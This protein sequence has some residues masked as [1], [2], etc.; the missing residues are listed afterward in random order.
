MR[1]QVKW[2][3]RLFL[4]WQIL[5]IISWAQ[6]EMP[7]IFSN[8]M[9]LQRHI[10]IPI[11]GT[12]A[13]NSAVVV[14]L[15]GFETKTQSGIDGKWKVY[16]PARSAGGPFKLRIING[17]QTLVYSDILIGEVWLCSGQSNMAFELDKSTNSEPD[18]SNAEN[19]NIRLFQMSRRYN[20]GPSVFSKEE[21]E[22]IE[23]GHFFNINPWVPSTPQSVAKFS[24]VAYYFGKKLSDSLQI[25]I[26]L[27]HNAIGGSTIE[28]W[29]NRENMLAHPQLSQLAT[30]EWY[31]HPNIHPWVG[32][33]VKKNL[34]IWLDNSIADKN[35]SHPFAPGYLY[36]H[37]IKPLLPYAIRGVIW[38]QGESNATHPSSYATLFEL[39]VNNWR[40]SWGQDNLPIYFVQLPRIANRSRWPEFREQQS[41]CL[42]IPNT[43]MVIA[44]DEGHRTNVHPKNKRPVGNRLALLALAQT[45]KYPILA[46][47]PTFRSYE[48]NQLDRKIILYFD[49][50]GSGLGLKKGLRPEGITIQGYRKKGGQLQII[51]PDQN[52]SHILIGIDL[53]E[54][55]III[56]YPNHFLITGVKYAWAPYPENNIINSAGLPMAPFKI[57]LEGNN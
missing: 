39:M 13:P 31:N 51:T 12:A 40:T 57:E 11:W 16:L 47:S 49:N 32:S 9:V 8:Q 25:P 14:R 19:P 6:I 18:I 52:L 23:N 55:R 26:G 38:Y 5:P 48:W 37:G 10:P 50:T 46:N 34:E 42:D 7:F 45:Y 1:F 17:E 44:I 29:I 21:M 20:L 35:L 36:N 27:I 53:Q 43:Y 41:A 33:R 4:F 54:E 56:T 2:R 28:S 22:N 30:K 15:G 24:A 3:T